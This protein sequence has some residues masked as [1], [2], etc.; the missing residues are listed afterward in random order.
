MNCEELH[1]YAFVPQVLE[2]EVVNSIL[3]AEYRV[4]LWMIAC[5]DICVLR[6]VIEKVERCKSLDSTWQRLLHAQDPIYCRLIEVHLGH[7]HN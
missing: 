3:E 5:G 2:V 4:D 1:Q 7:S 6:I